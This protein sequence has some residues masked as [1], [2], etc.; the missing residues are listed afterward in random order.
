MRVRPP[1]VSEAGSGNKAH[2]RV[3]RF[4]L[5]RGTG[6]SP[7]TADKTMPVGSACCRGTGLVPLTADKT[8]PVGRCL[9]LPHAL[10][11]V[12]VGV[13][14]KMKGGRK[15]G[16]GGGGGLERSRIFRLCESCV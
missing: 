1:V 4:T 8:T 9:I 12:S 14:I 16:G 13:D 11:F 6:L 2:G 10:S 7:L 3:T 5:C 15:G